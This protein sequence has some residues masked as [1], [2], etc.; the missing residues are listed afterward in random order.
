MSC[1]SFQTED[2]TT[3]AKERKRRS[4]GKP[5]ASSPKKSRVAKSMDISLSGAP[6][7]GA[8]YESVKQRQDVTIFDVLLSSI[9]VVFRPQISTLCSTR[10]SLRRRARVGR[11]EWPRRRRR[12][13]SA[14]RGTETSEEQLTVSGSRGNLVLEFSSRRSSRYMAFIS[15]Y[16]NFVLL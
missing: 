2:G 16:G 9:L 8:N 13:A 3:E 5:E 15:T 4:T 10:R 14:P 12:V 6:V 7:D 1:G 11:G